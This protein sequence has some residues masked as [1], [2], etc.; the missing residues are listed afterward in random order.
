MERND[1][2]QI[3]NQGPQNHRITAKAIAAKMST[4]REIFN[5]CT[6]EGKIYLPSYE[7]VTIYY[8]KDIL[9]GKKKRE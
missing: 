8:L 6:V 9:S 7:Q 5:F 2:A 3:P 4:K 1:P